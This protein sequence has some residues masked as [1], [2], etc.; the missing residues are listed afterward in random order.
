MNATLV[1]LR[2]GILLAV[3]LAPLAP[4][5]PA[6][7][8]S[9]PFRAGE[10]L[11]YRV[12]W[13]AFSS[14]A[15]LELSVP[16]RRD[17]FGRPTWHLRATAHTMNTVRSLF[18]IDDQSDSYSDTATFESRQYELHLNELGKKQDEILHFTPTG[19]ASLAPGPVVAVPPGTYDPLGALY[20][21]RGVDWRR[22]QEFHITVCDGHDVYEI[23]ARLD[24]SGETVAVDAGNFTANRISIHVYQR[25]KEVT[26]NSYKV[27]L[28]EDS[29]R[30]PVKM[31]AV[32][33]L[34]NI[35]AELT[36]ATQ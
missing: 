3:L 6:M 9:V 23:S 12:A 18:T 31:Q 35:R 29:A 32:L 19:K 30:T 33:P 4:A 20:A 21:L 17:L 15:S 34:G 24:A 10:T 5:P 1:Q 22:A 14:A 36:R 25:G 28:A 2:R 8:S 7:E 27:W 13:S 26:A 16:E 11:N